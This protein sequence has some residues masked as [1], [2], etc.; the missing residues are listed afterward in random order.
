[1]RVLVLGGTSEASVLATLIAERR[2]I[3][4]IMS[5][6]GRTKAPIAPPIPLRSGGFGGAEGLALYLEAERIDVV[7]DATHPFAE[8]ISRNAKAAAQ[9]CDIPL[10]I[11]SRPPWTRDA[12]DRW[13]GV[14]D[15]ASAAAALGR[16]SR[17]VFLAIGRLQIAAFEAAPQHFYLIR[18]I[19]P[20]TPSLPRHRVIEARGPFDAEAEE[21][22]LRDEMIEIVV[23]K[24]SGSAAVFGKIIAARRL[25]LPV[26]MVERPSNGADA[27][28]NPAEAL[29]LIL[30]HGARLAPRGV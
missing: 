18:S 19:E 24:N 3:E 14:P 22:L 15:M 17:R 12:T 6:A 10:V 9:R 1:M 16:V 26:V 30:R 8:Q 21:R 27:A 28:H 25:G 5:F 11:L 20:V 29:D 2:D 4:A 13:I 23:T 7:V